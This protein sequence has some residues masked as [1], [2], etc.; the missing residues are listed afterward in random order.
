[1]PTLGLQEML[2]LEKRAVVCL[3]E[4]PLVPRRKFHSVTGTNKW[5]AG[6]FLVVFFQPLPMIHGN[7][8]KMMNEY[9]I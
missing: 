3:L 8:C 9:F 5:K 1:M 2:S 4:G 7:Y 6:H